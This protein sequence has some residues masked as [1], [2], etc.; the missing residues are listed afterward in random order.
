[1]EAVGAREL[2]QR[3]EPLRGEHAGRLL[4]S[5]ARHVQRQIPGV[6]IED[7]PGRAVFG[8]DVAVEAFG[9][10]PDPIDDLRWLVNEDPVGEGAPLGPRKTM[11][12]EPG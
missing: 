7:E 6:D 3:R 9:V 1:M 10:L 2:D 5:Q 11:R 12:G 4:R 8:A